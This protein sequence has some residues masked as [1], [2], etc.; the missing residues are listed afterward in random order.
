MSKPQKEPETK[1]WDRRP[2]PD[3]GDND[4]R[5]IFAAIGESLTNWERLESSVALLF[6]AFVSPN[7]NPVPAKRAYV[8]VRTFEAR[9]EMLKAASEAFFAAGERK[10]DS[11]L[12]DDYKTFLTNI[13][14]FAPRRNEITHGVVDR[15]YKKEADKF[16]PIPGT[17]ALYPTWASFKDRT[18]EGAPSYC[19]ASQQV[20]YFSKRFRELLRPASGL[21]YRVLATRASGKTR[22]PDRG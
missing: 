17:V 1:P 10:S 21:V 3:Q 15:F 4:P 19:M 12:L 18:L 2:W 6:A 20:T 7:E 16:I 22:K 14:S 5:L 9:A 13:K 11:A 8:A